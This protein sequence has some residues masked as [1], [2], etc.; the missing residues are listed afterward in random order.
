[1]A[2]T[3]APRLRWIP[4][5]GALLA[6]ASVALAAFA[7]HADAPGLASAAWLGLIHGAACAALAPAAGNRQARVALAM[8]LA[9]AALFAGS[10]AAKHVLGLSSAPAPAG[11]LLMISG[12][13]VLSLTWLRR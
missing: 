6:G 4:G 13:V 12:W 11:G 8:L 5:L 1:M 9:G 3:T 7:A 10:L 2:P